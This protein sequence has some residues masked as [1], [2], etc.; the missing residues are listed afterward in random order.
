MRVYLACA[1]D[2]EVGAAVRNLL[3]EQ[4]H[5][6]VAAPAEPETS[7]GWQDERESNINKVDVMVV[8]VAPDM[9]MGDLQR[10]QA[11]L[12]AARRA[13]KRIVGLCMAPV[14]MVTAVLGSVPV[15]GGWIDLSADLDAGLQQLSKALLEDTGEASG[16][17]TLQQRAL[18]SV[19]RLGRLSL[20]SR[21]LST[22]EAGK[23]AEHPQG[24]KVFLSY[25]RRDEIAKDVQGELQEQ[26]HEVW[27][28]TTSIPGGD[29]WRASI[30]KG[31]RSADV[32]V[33]LIS[34]NMAQSPEH[35]Y[36][37][38]TLARRAEKKIIPVYLKPTKTL[39]EGFELILSGKQR[40]DLSGGFQAG[41]ERLLDV[42]GEPVLTEHL[43]VQD[44]ARRASRRVRIF[45]QEHEL[46]KKAFATG[47]AIAVG[48][49]GTLAIIKRQMEEQRA[50]ALRQMEEQRAKAL[51]EYRART[52]GLLERSLKE[53]LLTEGMTLEDY[54]VEFRP[55]FSRLL[56]QLEATTPPLS[57]INERHQKLVADLQRLLEEYDRTIDKLERG[58]V[59]AFKRALSRLNDAWYNIMTSAI[60]WLA[61]I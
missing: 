61:E 42:L 40:I 31:I 56:G 50:E 5:E 54:R 25:S 1:R 55:Q 28:D 19:R 51:T 59:S 16:E 22:E 34:P 52:S 18:Q 27:L 53:I 33:I 3:K 37:E 41:I 60:K 14:S 11:D 7:P 15:H 13:K 36:E 4:D 30:V 49:V 32:F 45:A 6:I 17:V 20:R 46:G 58:D 29:D 35:A 12:D 26:G 47:G 21:E 38:L 24:K 39:P 8:L 2:D 43:T 57:S 9:V 48:A 44:Q 23:A 10:L